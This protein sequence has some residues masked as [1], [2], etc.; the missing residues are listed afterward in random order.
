MAG[1]FIN[2]VT[3]TSAHATEEE[4]ALA[5]DENWSYTAK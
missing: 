4:A 5:Y 1:R 3:Y 2:E